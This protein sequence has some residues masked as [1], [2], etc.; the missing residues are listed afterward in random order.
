M[1]NKLNFLVALCITLNLQFAISNSIYSQIYTAKSSEIIFFSE[2]PLENIEAVNRSSKSMLN[3]ATKDIVFSIPIISFKFKKDLMR[4]HFN[5]K[6]MESDKFPHSTFNGKI[7][8]TIDFTK[9]GTYK[10]SASGKLSIHGVE[11]EE[12]LRGDLTINKEQ[13]E[14]IVKFKVLLEDY[15]IEIPTVVFYKIAEEILVTVS[16]IYVPH[17]KK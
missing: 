11:R 1:N 13:I 14:L 6:Y 9:N 16:V 2:A 8:E 5:E 15:D 4:E 7:N 3:T 10:I 12:T 17:N